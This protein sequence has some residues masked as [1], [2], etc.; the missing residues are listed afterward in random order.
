M[1]QEEAPYATHWKKVVSIFQTAFRDETLADDSICQTVVIILKG[2]GRYFWGIELVEVL[3]KTATGLLN[4]RFPSTIRFHDFLHGFRT[5]RVMGT[6]DLEA[7]LLQQLTAMR[8]AVLRDI[9]LDL[10]KAYGALDWDRCLEIL[11]LYG[12]VPRALRLLRTYWVRLTMVAKAGGYYPPPI[13]RL[14]WGNPGRPNSPQDI[15]RGS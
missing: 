3:W 14:P 13:Q 6:T 7:K 9:F 1:T 15:K 2:D 11:A 12:V 4:R 5:G 10:Q 8:K